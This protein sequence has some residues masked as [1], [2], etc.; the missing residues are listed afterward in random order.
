MQTTSPL[1]PTYLC[2]PKEELASTPIL[3]STHL[4]STL[5]LYSADCCSN[6][7]QQGMLTTLASIPAAC[8]CLP[9]SSVIC[10]SDPDAISIISGVVFLLSNSIYAPLR[11]TFPSIS[12]TGIFCLVRTSAT[13]E[14]SLVI[15]VYQAAAV[16]FASAGLKT[17]KFGILLRAASC[18]I[19]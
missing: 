18:S 16:S 5:S 6:N 17:L 14:H 4:G 11:A 10:T 3:Y 19:G 8:S 9:A 7:A 1:R 15:A 2:H 13:G 12:S